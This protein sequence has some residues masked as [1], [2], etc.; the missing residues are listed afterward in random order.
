[1]LSTQI[2]T[3]PSS[4]AETDSENTLKFFSVHLKFHLTMIY[5][6]SWHRYLF[7][8]TPDNSCVLHWNAP[9]I[10][11]LYIN[12]YISWRGTPHKIPPPLSSPSHV[13]IQVMFICTRFRRK[14]QR[15]VKVFINFDKGKTVFF[16]DCKLHVAYY[17]KPLT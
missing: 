17:F 15:S 14:L 2:V 3:F 4:E 16:F 10:W 13:F 8:V 11:D 9:E 7:F 12:K 6:S 5:S 1:M